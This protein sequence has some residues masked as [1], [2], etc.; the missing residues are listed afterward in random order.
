[1]LEIRQLEWGQLSESER[2][3]FYA[4]AGSFS[5]QVP[6]IPTVYLGA[7]WDE[8]PVGVA[9]ASYV[10]AAKRG[11]IEHIFVAEPFRRRKIASSLLDALELLLRKLDCSVMELTYPEDT[12]NRVILEQGLHLRGWRPS[13]LL[14]TRYS[15]NI[16]EFDTPWLHKTRSLPSDI[17]LHGWS[18]L[19]STERRRLNV[20]V[21]QGAYPYSVYPYGKG[22]EP[23]PTNSIFL[24]KED[25]LVGWLATHLVAPNTILYSGL[26]VHLDY[27]GK[28]YSLLLLSEGINRQ[29]SSSISIA[30]FELNA[31]QVSDM[32]QRFAIDS[33]APYAT[34]ATKVYTAWKELRD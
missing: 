30:C 14:L 12:P 26:Y 9:I 27:R 34:Q 1:M 7:Y 20:Q 4:L 28:G 17:T 11:E 16:Y 19:T 25:R 21:S 29:K 33:L 5:L 2:M 6:T 24:R 22:G 3:R 31:N 10:C 18:A 23:E 8:L 13:Y 32:W 15:Y